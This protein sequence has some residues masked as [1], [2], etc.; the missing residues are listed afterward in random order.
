MRFHSYFFIKSLSKAEIFPVKVYIAAMKTILFLLLSLNASA[1]V[2][3]PDN[4]A[5]VNSNN[6]SARAVAVMVPK[7]FIEDSSEV[8]GTKNLAT[9]PLIESQN[10]CASE[11]FASAPSFYVS[12]TGFLIAPDLLMTA[13]HCSVLFGETENSASPYCTD[14]DWY[15]GFEADSTGQVK[16]KNIPA[17]SIYECEKIIKAAHN[18]FMVSQTV[19]DFREDYSLIKLKKQVVGRTPLKLTSQRP[20]PGEAVTLIGHPLGGP[21]M[22]SAGKILS[23]EPTYDRS[24]VHSFSGNSGSPL[25]NAQGEV[26]GIL[27]RGYPPSLIDAPTGT[28]SVINRCNAEGTKCTQDDP[29]GQ[30]IGEHSMPI[31]QIPVLKEMGLVQ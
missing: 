6:M 9:V 31:G 28:C 22:I 29:D 11:K 23:N 25:L 18:S 3:G 7:S 17:D 5:F 8:P 10:M 12:C 2:Y 16:T 4:R 26:F 1:A 14:F 30:R 24:N 20:Q 27:V 13:G 15:F 19:I 21:K